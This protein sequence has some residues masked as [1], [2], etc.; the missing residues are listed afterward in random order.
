LTS[1]NNAFEGYIR[2]YLGEE[3]YFKNDELE[4]EQ[5]TKEENKDIV[6]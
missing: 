6:W 5:G 4:S 1:G 2:K 3:L